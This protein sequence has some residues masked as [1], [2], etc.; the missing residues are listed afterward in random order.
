MRKEKAYAYVDGGPGG[1][2]RPP[3]DEDPDQTDAPLSWYPESVRWQVRRISFESL[4]L[5]I[6]MLQG[7]IATQ[8]EA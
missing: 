3:L 5:L 7:G 2:G 1:W 8:V 6:P 4:K